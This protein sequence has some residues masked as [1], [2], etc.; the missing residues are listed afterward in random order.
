MLDDFRDEL[1]AALATADSWDKEQALRS[2]AIRV[3]HVGWN[4]AQSEARE[5]ADS[6]LREANR[7]AEELMRDS[8]DGS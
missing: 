8:G 5:I 7:I 1:E 4:A 6:A 2:L 3:K